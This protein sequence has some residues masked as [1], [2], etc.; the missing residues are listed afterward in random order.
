VR[1][2]AGVGNVADLRAAS[3]LDECANC[4]RVASNGISARAFTGKAAMSVWEALRKIVFALD[5]AK[6]P[7]ML[8]GSFAS[9]YYGVTR[10]TQDIDLVIAPTPGQLRVF[11]ESL[12]SDAYYVDLE[13]AQ[14]AL[15][16]HS[17]FN[18][19]DLGSGWKFDLIICKARA[20]SAEE[21]R[22]RQLVEIRDLPIYVASAE[23]VV[24]SKLEWSKKGKSR[25]Q[26]EDVSAILKI[27]W[28]FLDHPYLETWIKDLGL[29]E[30]WQEA[31]LAADI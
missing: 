7:Y 25:R 22:R 21:F 12:P 17:L 20:F 8:T 5:S 24:L 4:S 3:G 29:E 2:L 14:E 13:A 16:R 11:A 15:S 28:E 1:L 27:T 31:R 10:S 9:T 6:I 19:L 26:V 23:D 30:Q 18:V